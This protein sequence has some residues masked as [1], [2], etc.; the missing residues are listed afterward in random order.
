MAK[1]KTSES[2]EDTQPIQQEPERP[3]ELET[4]TIA[5]PSNPLMDEI[6]TF[7]TLRDELAR[8]LATEIE[9]WSRNWRI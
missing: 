5:D 1:K 4:V 8:K 9:A 7:M 2:N 6:Q 3:H